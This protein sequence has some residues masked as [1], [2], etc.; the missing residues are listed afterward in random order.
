MCPYASTCP[1]VCACVFCASA[2]LSTH[3]CMRVCMRV[4]ACLCEYVHVGEPECVCGVCVCVCVFVCHVFF[5]ERWMSHRHARTKPHLAMCACVSMCVQVCV[6]VMSPKC[7]HLLLQSSLVQKCVPRGAELCTKLVV[8][9]A[10]VIVVAM[11]RCR[12]M[13][14]TLRKCVPKCVVCCVLCVLCVVCV[15]CVCC[16]FSNMQSQ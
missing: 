8:W 13:Y 6:M 10:W 3:V 11:R 5:Q 7:N 4:H 14:Q 12:N 2:C 16:E 1:F 9:D 15:C